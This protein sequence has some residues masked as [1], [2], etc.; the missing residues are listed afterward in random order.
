[1]RSEGVLWAARFEVGGSDSPLRGR[2]GDPVTIV[3]TG[4]GIAPER[5]ALRTVEDL[6]P[7]A[8]GR[9]E[10]LRELAER[11]DEIRA[12]SLTPTVPAQAPAGMEAHRALVDFTVQHA[13]RVEA[14]TRAGHLPREP[15]GNRGDR[16]ELWENAVRQQMRLA[17]E[18]RAEANE[19]VT[20]LVNQ[21]VRLAENAAWFPG[22]EDGRAAVEE[23]IR[24]TIFES[25][26]P[27]VAAQR[28]WRSDWASGLTT[29]GEQLERAQQRERMMSDWLSEWQSWLIERAVASS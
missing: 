29:A 2:G 25:E 8:Y 9:Q 15:R 7:Y 23:S 4:R 21:M 3:V 16:G 26:V 28:A 22:T 12:A 17:G 20:A 5:V 11:R 6:E 18:D 27:S 1:M 19:A 24:Y 14:A 10:R 13:L